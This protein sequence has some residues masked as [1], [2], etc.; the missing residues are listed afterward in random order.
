MSQTCHVP[1]IT[2]L[3]GGR[4]RGRP[5]LAGYSGRPE[6]G[7]GMEEQVE[8]GAFLVRIGGWGRAEKGWRQRCGAGHTSPDLEKTRVSR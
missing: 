6:I 3:C 1:K 5:K 7:S 4:L 2:N 8:A